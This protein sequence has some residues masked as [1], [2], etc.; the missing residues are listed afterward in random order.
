M[1]GMGSAGRIEAERYVVVAA[2]NTAATAPLAAPTP[3]ID[4]SL[5]PL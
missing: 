3:R 2:V 1:E 4:R 5:I